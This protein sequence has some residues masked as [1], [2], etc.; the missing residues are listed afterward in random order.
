LISNFNIEHIYKEYYTEDDKR[1]N[2][3]GRRIDVCLKIENKRL[4]FE[5]KNIQIKYL[6]VN[7][8]NVSYPTSTQKNQELNKINDKNIFQ[9]KHLRQNPNNNQK[10][11]IKLT[12]NEWIE[13]YWKNQCLTYY[14]DL[15]KDKDNEGVPEVYLLVKIGFSKF[16]CIN[17]QEQ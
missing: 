3:S 9:L 11:L 13:K 17:I 14:K 15:L 7:V 5:L 16:L 1:K 10:D 8:D 12:I 4:C 6:D 2:K